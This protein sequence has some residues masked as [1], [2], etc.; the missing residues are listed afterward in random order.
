MVS[1]LEVCGHVGHGYRVETLH[2]CD[3]VCGLRE[4]DVIVRAAS[5]LV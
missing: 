5:T 3:F 2:D 4:C 1:R